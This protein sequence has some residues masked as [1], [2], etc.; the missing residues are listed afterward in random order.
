M[1]Q[2]HLVLLNDLDPFVNEVQIEISLLQPGNQSEPC[3][4]I[5]L[6]QPLSLSGCD[7]AAEPQLPGKR[8][9]LTEAVRRA[10]PEA[11]PP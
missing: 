10:L 3:S 9:L 5:F 4:Q 7:F 6:L 2:E 11:G 1:H 8:N